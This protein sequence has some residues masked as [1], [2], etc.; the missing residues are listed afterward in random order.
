MSPQIEYVEVVTHSDTVMVYRVRVAGESD[1]YD[2][3]HLP[4]G[5][6]T[7]GH[8]SYSAAVAALGMS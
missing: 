8:G 1:Q 3:R 7:S 5:F 4:S 2:A 6:W